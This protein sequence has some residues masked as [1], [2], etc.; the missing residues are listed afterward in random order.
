[1]QF[2]VKNI[3][4]YRQYRD[5]HCIGGAEI[6]PII[7]LVTKHLQGCHGYVKECLLTNELFSK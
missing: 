2:D 1:M 3:E 7:S 5:K 4:P 6:A